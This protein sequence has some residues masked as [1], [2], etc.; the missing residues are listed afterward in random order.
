M[1]PRERSRGLLVLLAVPAIDAAVASD[2]RSVGVRPFAGRV[3]GTAGDDEA[4]VCTADAPSLPPSELSEV[5]EGAARVGSGIDRRRDAQSA[6]LSCCQNSFDNLRHVPLVT[7]ATLS[8]GPIDAATL[9]R[10][11]VWSI[12]SC[13]SIGGP[14]VLVFASHGRTDGVVGRWSAGLGRVGNR[15]RR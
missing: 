4:M 6:T 2:G 13:W 14:F 5:A 12:V 11:R 9:A 8:A 15:H 10:Q 1:E 7:P 3:P